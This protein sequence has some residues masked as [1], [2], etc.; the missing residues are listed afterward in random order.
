MGQSRRKSMA[1]ML[2][3]Q[4]HKTLT[5]AFYEC[6]NY[7]AVIRQL[8]QTWSSGGAAGFLVGKYRLH[9]GQGALLI[10]AQ[11]GTAGAK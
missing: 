8:L 9:L 1:N 11:A 10:G 6:S 5:P 7:G 3:H 2:Q 4:H